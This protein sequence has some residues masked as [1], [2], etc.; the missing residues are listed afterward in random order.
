MISLQL[1]EHNNDNTLFKK[2][3][4]M[5]ILHTITVAIFSREKKWKVESGFGGRRV[6]GIKVI[7]GT[8]KDSP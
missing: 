1:P 8:S 6:G 4:F 5:T 3:K 2:K 7:E